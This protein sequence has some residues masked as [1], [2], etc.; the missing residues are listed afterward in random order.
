LNVLNSGKGEYKW[1]DGST[2]KGELLAG[3][4]H[5]HGSFAGSPDSYLYYDGS[6]I[7]GIVAPSY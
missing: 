5:G 1:P 3:L 4:R 6:W 7:K 2:Y